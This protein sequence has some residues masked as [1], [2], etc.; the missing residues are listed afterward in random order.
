MSTPTQKLGWIKR[1]ARRVQ[2]FYGI[3]RR[4]AIYDAWIDWIMFNGVST[5]GGAT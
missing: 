2:S 1:R 5:T 4:L 3:S